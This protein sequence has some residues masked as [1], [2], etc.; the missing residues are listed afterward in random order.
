MKGPHIGLRP[1]ERSKLLGGELFFQFFLNGSEVRAD[2]W[3]SV[4]A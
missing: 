1:R 2:N 3:I 4:I